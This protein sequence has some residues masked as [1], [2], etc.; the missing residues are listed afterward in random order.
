MTGEFELAAIGI[1]SALGVAIGAVTLH[2]VRRI[3]QMQFEIALDTRQSRREVEAMYRQLEALAAL[4]HSS[5][6]LTF[7]CLPCAV[8]QVLRTSC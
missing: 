4:N 8:G 5:Q 6:A 3:H 1:L 7:P 2:K